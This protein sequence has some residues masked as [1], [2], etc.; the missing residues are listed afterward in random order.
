MP[1]DQANV[2]ELSRKNNIHDKVLHCKHLIW[3]SAHTLLE[4][5]EAVFCLFS[6]VWVLTAWSRPDIRTFYHSCWT[7]FFCG[8]GVRSQVLQWLL[9]WPVCSSRAGPC[10][11][12]LCTRQ[13]GRLLRQ[14]SPK[15]LSQG[16]GRSAE[17]LLLLIGDRSQP[18]RLG[19]TQADILHHQ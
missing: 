4:A 16:R 15:V 11:M 7:F 12:T 6:P 18:A 8:C 2:T 9:S 19:W 14:I 10:T 5:Y 17:L 3:H 1:A 13:G